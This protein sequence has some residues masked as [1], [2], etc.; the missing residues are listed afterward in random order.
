MEPSA[1]QSSTSPDQ[2]QQQH[3]PSLYSEYIHQTRYARW[4][5]ELGRRE[6]YEESVS[7][8][9]DFCFE[10]CAKQGYTMSYDELEFIR[11]ALLKTEAMCSM[12][13]LMTAGPAAN[14]DNIAIYNCTYIAVDDVRAF[15]ETMYLLM[16]GTGVGFSVERQLVKKLPEVPDRLFDCADVLTVEDNR[17]SWASAY[18]RLLA[19]LYAGHIP[20]WDVSRLRPAGARLKTFGGR[21]SGPAP[22]IDLFRYTVDVFKGATGRQLTSIECHGLMCKIGDIVVAGG[23]RRS[24]LI[25]LSNPSDERM[26]D[27]KS[28][29]WR[30][31]NPHF[32][33]ANNSA[34]WTEKPDMGRFMKEWVSLYESKSGERGIVNRQAL[35]AQCERIGRKTTYEDGTPIPFGV[36][37]CGEIILRPQQCCN[38][39]EIVARVDDTLE[40]LLRKAEM[41]T[42]MGTIQ[43]TCT[44]FD[45]VRPIWKKNCEEERLL[46]VGLTGEMDHPVLSLQ[47]EESARWKEALAQRCD[48]VNEEWAEKLGI[49][50]SMAITTQKPSGTVSQLVDCASGGHARFAKY[51]VRRTRDSKMDPVAEVVRM[52]GVPCE[53]DNYKTENWVFDWPIKAPDGAVVTADLTAIDQLERWLHTKFNYTEHNP[54]CTIQVHE[55]EWLAVGAWVYEHFDEVGGLS[56]LPADPGGHGYTQLPYEEITQEEYERRVAEMP[57][58]IDWSMLSA[59]EH[60]D[61]TTG[62][63]ELSC[64][65]GSCD[66]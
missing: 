54:S 13:A 22:L 6:T 58:S 55:H 61:S 45:Y 19:M 23:V 40:D 2:A 64:S 46:G 30:S 51:Y 52:A 31:V 44:D 1:M 21:S 26:R 42:I 25:S 47:N 18:R 24:A 16:C 35:V 38:L 28:G 66:L 29:D 37:P 3:L 63:R 8:Y 10:Q 32:E 11:S 53:Q 59:I 36:N 57:K 39:T 41:A 9:L 17:K 49:N 62:S 7:R 4:S 34:V 20:T 14:R 43:S 60:E 56:F 65:A 50:Q 5:D 33:L 27:A 15:D 48:Q 12:R